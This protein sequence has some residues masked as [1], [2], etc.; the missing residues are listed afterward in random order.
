[1]AFPLGLD[2]RCEVYFAPLLADF[3]MVFDVDKYRELDEDH[4]DRIGNAT[5][6][7]QYRALRTIAG[8]QS[9]LPAVI[10]HQKST[11]TAATPQKHS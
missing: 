3:V 9:T 10:D 5:L 8:A 7:K 1:M 6:K 4:P 11:H 2:G